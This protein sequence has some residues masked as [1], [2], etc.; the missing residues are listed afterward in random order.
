M[1]KFN[2]I[3]YL[4]SASLLMASAFS[5]TGCGSS[6][7][8]GGTA[9]SPNGIYT[10]SITGGRGAPFNGQEKG[11]IYNNRMMVFSSVNSI[12]QMFE[13]SLIVSGTNLSGAI[14]YYPD[15]SLPTTS[16]LTLTG[17]FS[18]NSS[19]TINF[20]DATDT[21][22]PDGTINLVSDTALFNKGSDSATLA[23]TWQGLHGLVGNG[24]TIMV[25]GAGTI[26]G[27]SDLG[28]TYT[29]TILPVDTSI[30]IYDVNLTT[31][32]DCDVATLELLA[33]NTTYTGF[34]W[35]EGSNDE[36]LNFTVSD[37]KNS[38]SIVLTRN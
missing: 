37:G 12:R 18:P 31:G 19:A 6:G 16:S 11:V 14:K 30:N 38:R 20:T 26:T 10:G 4:V 36:T 21:Q 23:F 27:S 35:T 17:N 7:G 22:P 13:S 2:K 9:A 15:S 28:C 5:I 3:R 24:S 33:N 29:G 32:S 25:S 34:A 1:V 8:G